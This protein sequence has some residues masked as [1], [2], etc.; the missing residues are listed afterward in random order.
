MG[1][2][3]AE[4]QPDEVDLD[5]LT[6][7]IVSMQKVILQP[8]ESR[9]ISGT[10]KGPIRTAGI[11]KRVN[12][13]TEPTN[14]QINEGSH[15]S[16]VPSYTYVSPGS[17]RAKIMLKNLAARP[18]TVGRGQTIATIKPGNKVPKMLAPKIDD[19]ENE[20]GLGVDARVSKPEEGPWE[21]SRVYLKQGV[22]QPTKRKLLTTEQLKELHEKLQLEEH[23]IGWGPELK[24]ELHELVKEYSFLFTMDSMDLGKTDLIQHHIELTDYTPIKDRYRPIPPHQYDEVRKHLKEMLEI[25][26]IRKSNSPWASPVVLVRKKD[27]SLRF[28]IDLCQLNARTIKDAYSLPRIEDALDSLDGACIF[29]SL[30]LKSGYWQVELDEESIP[31]TAFTVGPLGF[32][33]CVRMPF[34][35]TNAPATFQ[36]LMET[37]LGELHLNW[38]IIYLD[39]IIIFSKMPQEHL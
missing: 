12:V 38:C 22:A 20:S 32:Y 3:C 28:C 14:T 24:T 7:S 39:D 10:T 21:G 4:I 18:V 37:C 2:A 9:V 25:G 27:G 33:E 23:T 26:A 34:G 30:D 16:A 11:S 5:Q 36:H 8:F 35:L 31:L 29:M 1:R 15:F 13:L 17:S 6:G 19:T